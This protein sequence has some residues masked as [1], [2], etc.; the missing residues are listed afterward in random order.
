M[1]APA[2]PLLKQKSQDMG[3]LRAP[4]SNTQHVA[5]G[6]NL[7]V[8]EIIQRSA[9][10]E[11]GGKGNV[12]QIVNGLAALIKKKAVQLIQIGNTVFMI[13]PKGGGTAEF[14]TFTVESPKNL[15]ERFKAGAKV[16]KQMGFKQAVTY[17]QSPAFVRMAQQS[18]LP[19]KINQGQQ[20]ISGQRKPTYQFVLDL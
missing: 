2:E 18:G 16:L 20:T 9:K 17:S 15:V 7:S 12:N 8:M 6:G 3:S 19:V 5:E 1:V 10:Q 11:M 13:M 4:R 14:H